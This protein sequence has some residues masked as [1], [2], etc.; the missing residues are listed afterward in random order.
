MDDQGR[1]SFTLCVAE[2]SA[3]VA[4]QLYG[5]HHVPNALAAAAAAS[6]LGLSVPDIAAALNGAVALSRWRME[7]T[8]RADGLVVVNDAYNANPESMRAALRALTGMAAGRRCWAVLGEMRELG[9]ASL[10]EHEDLGRFAADLGV[11]R[12]IAVGRETEA[13]VRGAKQESWTGA[14]SEVPDAH[15]AIALLR[16]EVH[17]G[18]FVLVKASRAVGLERVAEALLAD[19]SVDEPTGTRA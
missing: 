16:A 19:A 17:P 4:M 1:A 3:P 5:A 13:I 14:A 15:A 10:Q 2:E 6:A 11:S 12:L 18:D 7:V 8:T 9:S